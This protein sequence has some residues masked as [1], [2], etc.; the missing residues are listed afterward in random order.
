VKPEVTVEKKIGETETEC[1][2][3]VLLAP[4]TEKET[5]SG[6]SAW[7]IVLI[8][9]LLILLVLVIVIFVVVRFCCCRGDTYQ[10]MR[11]CSLA[12]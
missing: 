5:G 11:I 8:V 7:W 2:R 3:V 9:I 10:R 12:R 6:T 1:M 4:D